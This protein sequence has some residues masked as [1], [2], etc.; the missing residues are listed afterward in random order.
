MSWVLLLGLSL[1]AAQ[2]QRAEV[3]R[4]EGEMDRLS[5]R[6]AW[7]GVE[8]AYR[9]SLGL[10]VDLT[11][12]LHWFGAQAALSQG[13]TMIAWYRLSR[14]DPDEDGTDPEQLRQA[15]AEMSQLESGYGLVAISVSAQSVAAL[16]R[17]EMPFA[18]RER[19]AIGA[20]RETVRLERAF[21]GLLPVGQYRID[22][23]SFDVTAGQDRWQVVVV[24]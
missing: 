20:A 1:A 12:D 16:T 5:R 2:D 4:L 18:Q 8:R 15:E 22:T 6:N 19:D 17:A 13:N 9:E 23:E 24:E 7:G 11:N 21:R 3:A 14:L 10:E